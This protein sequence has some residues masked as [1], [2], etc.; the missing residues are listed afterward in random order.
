VTTSVFTPYVLGIIGISNAQQAVVT[1]ASAHP[2]TPGEILSFRVSKPYG[3][4]EMNNVQATVLSTTEYTVT[5]DIDTLGFNAFVYPPVGIVVAPS[6]SVPAGSG[7]IPNSNP[8][9]VNL[10]D[11]FDN[12]PEN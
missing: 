4:V 5:M 11:V 2:Y 12:L 8:S 9:T 1:F 3:M 10:L 7:I 6:V